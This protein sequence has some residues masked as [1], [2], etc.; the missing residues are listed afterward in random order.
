M[1]N[2]CLAGIAGYRGIFGFKNISAGGGRFRLKM[3]AAG[4]AKTLP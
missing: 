1:R 2:M 4:V 3:P